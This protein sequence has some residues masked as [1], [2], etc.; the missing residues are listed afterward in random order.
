MKLAYITTD[1]E[2][3]LRTLLDNKEKGLEISLV[4]TNNPKS[5]V[6]EF[7]SKN[8]L[9]CKIINDKEFSSREEHDFAIMKELDEADVDLVILGGYRR[10]IKDEEFLMKYGRK[11]INIHN[12]FL[13]NFPGSRPHDE[14]FLSGVEKSGCTIHFV[15]AVMDR[16]DIILQEEV[17]ISSCK[18]SQDVYDKL[19][20]AGCKGILKILTSSK[21]IFR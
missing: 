7:C 8:K 14:A 1:E 9:H 16:G 4:I 15:D 2:R 21:I 12:S 19:V 6:I 18:N 17:D 11:M 13:P 3:Y 10:L 5:P 20:E